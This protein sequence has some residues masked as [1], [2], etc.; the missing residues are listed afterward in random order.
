MDTIFGTKLKMGQAFFDNKRTAVTWI[1]TGPC[2]V[3]QIKTSQKDGY[4]AVQLGFGERR[5]KNVSK[6]MQGHLKGAIINDKAPRFLSEVKLNQEPEYKVG[7]KIEVSDIFVAGDKV[8]VTGISK[9]K[10]FAGVVKRHH[11]AGGPRTHG[12]SDR[13]RAPGS[14]GQTTT[15][16]RVFKGKA[17]AG[18][19]GQE[20]VTIKNLKVLSVNQDKDEIA[21]SG[22]IPGANGGLVRITKTSSSKEKDEGSQNVES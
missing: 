18:R 19:M 22:S 2:I 14:I 6:P 5:I 10:G 17:M 7:D 11:F 4:W 13:E 12:Q 20:R 8:R 16:G 3:T 9:G 15:P 21:L 1:K